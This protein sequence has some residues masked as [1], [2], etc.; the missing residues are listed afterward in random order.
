MTTAE[1]LFLA[2]VHLGAFAIDDQGGVWRRWWYATDRR[3]RVPLLPPRRATRVNTVGYLYV[4]FHWRGAAHVV[5]AHRV[6]YMHARRTVLPDELEVNHRNGRK[7]DN[8]PENLA[9][10]TAKENMAHSVRELG[11]SH[12]AHG[13]RHHAAKLTWDAVQEIR[14]AVREGRATQIALCRQFGVA[15]ATVSQIV[16]GRT[17]RSIEESTSE[18]P[19][20]RRA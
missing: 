10:V 2:F 3:T 17:W 11:N 15:P 1:G 6:V 16:S 19:T 7:Q 4:P 20:D 13:E 8:R 14:A 5:M 18:S 12:G 9:A